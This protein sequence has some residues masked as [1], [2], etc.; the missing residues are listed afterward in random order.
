MRDQAEDLW[1][2]IGNCVC[3]QMDVGHWC[4]GCQRKL[5]TIREAFN[6]AIRPRDAEIERL[7]AE[8]SSPQQVNHG[9]RLGKVNRRQE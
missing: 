1:E 7:R 8:V 3:C 9:I 5:Q 6:E 4:E 2:A